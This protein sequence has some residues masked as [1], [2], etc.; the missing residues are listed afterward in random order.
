M[1]YANENERME[2]LA[3]INLNFGKHKGKTWGDVVSE[4]K[5]Y[6]E[7]LLT[8]SSYKPLSQFLIYRLKMGY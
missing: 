5:A 7:W 6:S 1:V 3:Q 2:K 8:I 4:D